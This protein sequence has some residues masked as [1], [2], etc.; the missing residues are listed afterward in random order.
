MAVELFMFLAQLD[1]VKVQLGL[2]KAQLDL[3]KPN[4]YTLL[5]SGQRSLIYI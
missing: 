5:L 4:K 1:L 2:V 3:T